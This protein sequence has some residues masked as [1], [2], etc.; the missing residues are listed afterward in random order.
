[1]PELW[2]C[3]KTDQLI[4]LANLQ[5][6]LYGTTLD[7]ITKPRKPPETVINID[8]FEEDIGKSISRVDSEISPGF[9]EGI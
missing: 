2:E 9:T 7:I 4:A 5:W 1:M 3:C 6:E 8:P